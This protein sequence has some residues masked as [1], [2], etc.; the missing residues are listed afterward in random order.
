MR[1]SAIPLLVTLALSPARQ[2]AAAP[3]WYWAYQG[4]GVTAHGRLTTDPQPDA[5]GSY[6]VTGITGTRNGVAIVRLAAAGRPIPGNA[7]YRVDNRLRPGRSP[8]TE[9]GLGYALA[10]GSYAAAEPLFLP[11]NG[12]G[13]LRDPDRKPQGAQEIIRKLFDLT[14]AETSLALLLTNGL[15]LEE[16]ADELAISKNTA[17]SHLRAIFSK[18]GVTRQATLVR[19]LLN[20]VLSL[21]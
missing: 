1:A 8:L 6:R 7:P 2:V 10:D 14:P 18:T 3:V 19:M 21:G 13:V 17:R 4:A 20:S 9:A 16:A 12:L 15:T 5:R 11:E